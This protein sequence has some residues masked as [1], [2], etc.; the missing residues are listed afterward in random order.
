M[1]IQTHRSTTRDRK[2]ERPNSTEKEHD[3]KNAKKIQT[4]EP[5]RIKKRQKIKKDKA[6]KARDEEKREETATKKKAKLP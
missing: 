1:T 3:E 4:A 5:E 2:F 6:K